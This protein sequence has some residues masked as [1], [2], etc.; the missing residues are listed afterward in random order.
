MEASTVAAASDRIPRAQLTPAQLAQTVWALSAV[1]DYATGDALERAQS[2]MDA[3][4]MRLEVLPAAA[5][6]SLRPAELVAAVTSVA[7]W[8][9]PG[10]ATVTRVIGQLSAKEETG[11]SRADSVRLLWSAGQCSVQ[12][13]WVDRILEQMRESASTLDGNACTTVLTALARMLSVHTSAVAA[14]LSRLD[15]VVDDLDHSDVMPCCWALARHPFVQQYDVREDLSG[16]GG[17]VVLPPYVRVLRRLFDRAA[18]FAEL[19]TPVEFSSLC[20]SSGVLRVRAHDLVAR[21]WEHHG[22]GIIER[23][24]QSCM[25][26]TLWGFSVNWRLGHPALLAL[27]NRLEPHHSCLNPLVRLHRHASL[28]VPCVRRIVGMLPATA[29]RLTFAEVVPVCD[30]LHLLVLLCPANDPVL[31]A[32]VEVGRA[33][34]TK[35]L[36]Q[37][38]DSGVQEVHRVEFLAASKQLGSLRVTERMFVAEMS[39]AALAYVADVRASGGPAS[40]G[41]HMRV[42]RVAM[43]IPAPTSKNVTGATQPAVRPRRRQPE[44]PA[45]QWVVRDSAQSSG[46]PRRKAVRRTVNVD[47]GG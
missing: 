1:L 18:D 42:A 39:A 31:T 2:A 5:Y 29:H 7:R 22:A 23:M 20:W 28:D 11:F 3:V 40:I 6:R 19:W 21:V 27:S 41:Q 24:S 43:Q 33:L 4:A 17:E 26:A 14:V 9:S 34:Y 8:S 38:L 47:E 37:M 45:L 46:P 25:R 12:G 15:A 35:L 16:S 32:A 13:D 44:Q 30:G 36:P 10:A